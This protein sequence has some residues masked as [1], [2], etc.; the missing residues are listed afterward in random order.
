MTPKNAP[1]I[2]IAGRKI[3]TAHS[4]YIICEL[5]G[6]HNGSLDRALAL[7]DAAADTGC[8]AIKLQTYTADTIT[9][10]SDR[11]EFR[12]N[13]GLWDGRTLYDLYDE[14]HTP[15]D[16][17]PA[18]FERAAKR[19]VTMF[20]SPF[21]DTAVDFLDGLGAP[22]FKIASFELI[23]LPLVAYAASKG[24]PL[25]MSTGMANLSEIEAAVAIARQHGTG[26]IVLLHC[27]SEYPARIED[28]NVRVVPD[29]GAKFGCPSGLSD[30]T[31]G[32]AASVASIALG[33]CVIEKHFTLARADGGPDSGFSLEP[34]EFTA[35]VR[36]CKD[37]WAALGRVH[38]DLVGSERTSRTFRRSL[39]V[40]ADVKAG[41][42]FSKANVRSVRPGLGLPPVR[43][44]DVLGKTAARDI[45]S[46]EPLSEDMIG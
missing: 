19:D 21:D 41:E 9:L 8:D 23:D 27:V 14:A 34:D 40:V 5:S 39:Y 15:W 25:I 45:V 20:S 22:A 3:G 42:A 44:W 11:L 13:G 33:G 26:E 30:H 43:L 10:K 24:K 2:S 18:L 7:V 16:W 38:Y 29:L 4:P 37:A 1:E 28:A 36:D 6:N 35:L 12:I 32:T 46:G 31:F 17:H